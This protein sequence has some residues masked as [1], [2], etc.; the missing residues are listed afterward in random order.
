MSCEEQNRAK[1]AAARRPRPRAAGEG[2][3]DTEPLREVYREDRD[4]KMP[5]QRFGDAAEGEVI[6][7]AGFSEE[8]QHRMLS[9]KETRTYPE[10]GARN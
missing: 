1:A 9:W 8:R 4:P 7:T 2:G 3:W 6:L 10:V 5:E